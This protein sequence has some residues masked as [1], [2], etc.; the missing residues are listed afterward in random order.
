MILLPPES[1]LVR[2]RW[3]VHHSL[4]HQD[5]LKQARTGRWEGGGESEL[6]VVENK[7]AISEPRT[8]QEVGDII[9][10]P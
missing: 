2:Y 8:V 4:S 10:I 5:G 9:N 3:P 6:E 7:Q 1:V